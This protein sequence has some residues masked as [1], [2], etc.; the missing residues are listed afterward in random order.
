MKQSQF[1]L[2]PLRHLACSPPTALMSI[3][4]KGSR[5]TKMIVTG[6][7]PVDFKDLD[8]TFKD[9]PY[10]CSGTVWIEYEARKPSNGLWEIEWFINEFSEVESCD[11]DGTVEL[12]DND[13]AFIKSLRTMV[14]YHR[15]DEINTAVKME[16]EDWA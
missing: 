10:T 5:R 9:K 7:M 15:A 13:E 11:E 4:P 2:L 3:T 8:L 1:V 6:E 14:A 12:K 16:V